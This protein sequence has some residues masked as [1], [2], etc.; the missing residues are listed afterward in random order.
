MALRELDRFY[1]QAELVPRDRILRETATVIGVGAIGH[2]L[3]LQLTA[4]GVPRL[5]LVDFGDVTR[6]NV[7]SHGHLMNDIGRPKVEATGD[8]CHQIEHLLSIEEV[9]DRFR[10]TLE[11]GTS[12]FCCVDS[13]PTRSEIWHSVAAKCGFWA[14]GRILGETVRIV[15][16]TPNQGRKHYSTTL[17]P[18]EDAQA[19]RRTSH[20]TICTAALAASL[21]VH[22]ITRYL[23]G[24]PIDIDSTFN[25]A[26]SEFIV[27]DVTE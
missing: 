5:Q 16:A 14:D 17:F 23:R 18:Q 10:P 4:L 9:N 11:F 21:M 3:A 12:I 27:A 8:A 22:Q 15:I 25:L 2:Q 20:S 26:A 19:G 7:T 6:T 1:R 13:M 24:A